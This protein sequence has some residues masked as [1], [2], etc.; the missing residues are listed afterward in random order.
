MISNEEIKRIAYLG[1]IELSKEE[2]KMLQKQL[3]EI[4]NFVGQFSDIPKMDI[5]SGN[6]L[7]GLENIFRKDAEHGLL[8]EKGQ[9]LIKQAPKERDSFVVVPEVLKGN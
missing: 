2:E 8:K 3:P 4:I 9:K 6:Q 7:M 1:R 5:N